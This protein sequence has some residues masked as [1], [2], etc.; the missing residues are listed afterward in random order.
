MKV[1]KIVESLSPNEVKV[2][3]Y[4]SEKDIDDICKKASLDKVSVLRALEFF[5]E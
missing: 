1:T 2:L 5:A 4:L 3:P